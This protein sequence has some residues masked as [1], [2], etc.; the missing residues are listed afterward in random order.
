[1]LRNSNSSLTTASVST[2][3]WRSASAI[4]G[5]G[6]A[7]ATKT[8][9]IPAGDMLTVTVVTS[10]VSVVTIPLWATVADRIGR[11]PVFVGGMLVAAVMIF[12]YFYALSTANIWFVFAAALLQSGLSCTARSMTSCSNAFPTTRK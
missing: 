8:V 10:V 5:F 1:M 6:L 12:G 9:G 2:A 3:D 4:P 7:Y 11:K